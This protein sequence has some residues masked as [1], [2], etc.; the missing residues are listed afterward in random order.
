MTTLAFKITDKSEITNPKDVK[1][2]FDSLGFALYF[3]RS[4][5][6]FGR[7]KD[8]SFSTY[9]HLGV[10]AYTGRFLEIFR[11]LPKGKLEEIEKLEQLRAVEYGHSIK[12]IITR[13]DSP[14]VD[15]PEDIKKMEEL[16]ANR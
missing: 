1:V 12:V 8:I 9:K 15:L 2:V 10:Y 4:P 6:P 3:S 14:E 13:F 7:D 16:I 11:K 5:I